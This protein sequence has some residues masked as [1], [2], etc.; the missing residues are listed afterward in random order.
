MAITAPAF[1]MNYDW[2]RKRARDIWSL[3]Y[4]VTRG[5]MFVANRMGHRLL[6]DVDNTVDKYLLA[7]GFYENTQKRTLFAAARDAAALGGR[8]VFVD[9]GAHWGIY[10]LWALGTGLF[11]RVMA[12]EA[13]QRN[14]HQLYANLFLN[15]LSGKIDVVGAAAAAATGTLEFSPASK[16][17]RVVSKV[18]SLE[19]TG[20]LTKR[21][22]PAVR[23]DDLE[24]ISGGVLVAKIDVEGYEH[25]VVQGM[26]RLLTQNRCVLQVEVFPN[27]FEGFTRM[28][29]GLGY[30]RFAGV[31][32]DHYYRNF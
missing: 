6:L 8:C 21:I 16:N 28:M 23:L 29:A 24:S 1:L 4:L 3:W 26:T 2:P 7:F 32:N 17:A 10:A 27:A 9:V 5:R 19:T 30:T 12:V 20:N 31:A 22:V 18:S 15:D 13:D 14:L 11:D 25:E